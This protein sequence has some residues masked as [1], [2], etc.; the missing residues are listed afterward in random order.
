MTENETRTE[1]TPSSAAVA[2]AER[3]KDHLSAYPTAEAPSWPTQAF[4]GAMTFEEYDEWEEARDVE[5]A[6]ST[7][8]RIFDM[9]LDNIRRDEL[10]SAGD[11]ADAITALSSQLSERLRG[12][13]EDAELASGQRAA[14]E[15]PEAHTDDP[16]YFQVFRDKSGSWRW[17][18]LHSNKFR[19]KE[20]EI[21][22]DKAHREWVDYVWRTKAFPTLRLFHVP[23]DFGVAD[24]V[25]YDDQGFVVSS[26]TFKAEAEDI[27][28]ELA[29]RKD[30]GCSH[31]F[32]YR[33]RDLHG[34]V[35]E[36]YR[37]FEVS[38]LPRAKAANELT[39]FFAGEAFPVIG[40]AQRDF[41]IE[42]A[43]EDR[44]KAIEDG[45]R[46]MASEAHRR[47]LSYKSIEDRIFPDDEAT[48][49]KQETRR[50]DGEDLTR[51]QFADRGEAD[52]VTT[53]KLP[54]HDEEHIA[55][56]ITALQP[57][58]FRGNPVSLTDDR[59]TVI[60]RIR[61]AVRSLDDDDA[62]ERL[63]ERLSNL[64][65]SR[66]AS[67]EEAEMSEETTTATA[68][69]EEEEEAAAAEEGAEDGGTTPAADDATS[70]EGDATESGDDAT[71]EASPA[72]AKSADPIV[73][74]VLEQ[75]GPG[76]G[77]AVKHAVN[78]ALGEGLK[79]ITEQVAALQGEIAEVKAL[80]P[81]VEGLR[82]SRDEEV[83]SLIYPRA[84]PPVATPPSESD[85]NIVSGEKAEGVKAA[86]GGGDEPKTADGKAVTELPTAHA[87]AD[88]YLADAFQAI[89]RSPVAQ[90]A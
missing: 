51:D 88:P 82:A 32:S 18:A 31:G 37:T 19:D 83:A 89:Q 22:S 6:V 78:D 85:G 28:E 42:V 24:W 7:Q 35:F 33:P 81:V 54:I 27:A 57:G 90:T 29:G 39:A 40:K 25:G 48:A 44:T 86:A 68:A 56:A 69:E 53:W 74:A 30:L 76:L 17:L 2:A 20:G 9:L 12:A 50:V 60:S 62:K 52:N 79:P 1:S 64:R 46:D 49:T 65:G 43:G 70:S 23:A 13:Q 4:G 77:I 84:R 67:E 26:G 63:N 34:G 71:A 80:G 21:F 72:A 45:I 10:M 5:M 14:T 75:I 16:G 15:P 87:A 3:A 11:K 73:Q 38:V 41:L 61:S 66:A 8:M 47:G 36:R 59:S 55:R 58:G